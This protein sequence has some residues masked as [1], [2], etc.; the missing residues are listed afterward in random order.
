MVQGR[1]EVVQALLAMVALESVEALPVMQVKAQLKDWG[2][3]SGTQEIFGCT[4]TTEFIGR[5]SASFRGFSALGAAGA[6]AGILEH[7]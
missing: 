4:Y 7:F 1:A 6:K 3:S 5:N 2:N